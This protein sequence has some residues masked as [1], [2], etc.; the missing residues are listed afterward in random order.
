M[1][2]VV[3][4]GRHAWAEFAWFLRRASASLV[5]TGVYGL[6]SRVKGCRA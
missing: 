5:K 6:G 1:I 3:R 4:G 2:E